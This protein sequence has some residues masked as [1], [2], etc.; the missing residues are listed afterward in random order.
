MNF[1]LMDMLF[2]FIVQAYCVFTE[3]AKEFWDSIMSSCAEWNGCTKQY[4]FYTCIKVLQYVCFSFQ[5][6]FRCCFVL[7]YHIK[8][9][10]KIVCC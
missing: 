10:L 4:F 9:L 5:I 2:F 8:K 1:L 7:T 3:L 6:K